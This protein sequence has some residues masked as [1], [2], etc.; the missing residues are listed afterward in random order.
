MT[1]ILVAIICGILVILFVGVMYEWNLIIR[2]R[3]VDIYLV[4]TQILDDI[5]I[6]LAEEYSKASKVEFVAEDY[7]GLMMQE[8]NKYLVETKMLLPKPIILLHLK[9]Y[10]IKL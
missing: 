6:R 7:N 2:K 5:L 10:L 4:E 1:D 3:L 9:K 8:L